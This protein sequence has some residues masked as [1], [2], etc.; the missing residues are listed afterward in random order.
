MERNS[1]A[2]YDA[3]SDADHGKG[4]H[5]TKDVDRGI[6]EGD[7]QVV[8]YEGLEVIHRCRFAGCLDDVHA[9]GI[10]VVMSGRVLG[11]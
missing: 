9:L 4:D 11:R 3:D 6:P 1:K 7:Q 10:I 8:C 2:T 5:G